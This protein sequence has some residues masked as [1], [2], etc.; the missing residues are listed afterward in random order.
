MTAGCAEC[1]AF[2]SSFES[3]AKWSQNLNFS[4]GIVD[5]SKSPGELWK[6]EVGRSS[7]MSHRDVRNTAVEADLQALLVAYKPLGE[8]STLVSQELSILL[9]TDVKL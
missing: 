9:S 8:I 3:L 6:A 2:K 1:E 5:I 4:L 7:P